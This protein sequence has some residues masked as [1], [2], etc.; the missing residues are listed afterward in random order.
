VLIGNSAGGLLAAAKMLVIGENVAAVYE[1][2]HLGL[3]K[4]KNSRATTLALPAASW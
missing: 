4:G 2:Y 1:L 3:H